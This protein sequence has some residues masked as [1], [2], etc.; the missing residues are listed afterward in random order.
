MR[1][2]SHLEKYLAHSRISVDIFRMKKGRLKMGDSL[3]V[4]EKEEE[5]GRGHS[6]QEAEPEFKARL[7]SPMPPQLALV[8]MSWP[9][10]ASWGI[11]IP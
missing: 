10:W 7:R 11:S 3:Y 1:D 9:P 6:W 4:V 8:L 2:V 5:T